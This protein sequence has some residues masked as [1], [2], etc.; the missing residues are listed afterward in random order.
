MRAPLQTAAVVFVTFA[1]GC[2]S[3]DSSTSTP[4]APTLQTV[5]K[6]DGALHVA[7]KNA[8]SSCDSIEGESQGTM[9]D[10]TIHHK[11]KVAFT[12]PGD[13]DNKHDTTATD[14][15]TYT[16]RLRCKKG[17]TYS[18]YSNEISANPKK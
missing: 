18:P 3:E 15:M 16:Y 6:M 9:A 11:Y 17:S 10:G 2:S 12:V 8:D 7:W 13:V 14:D 1:L 4:T 5:Q